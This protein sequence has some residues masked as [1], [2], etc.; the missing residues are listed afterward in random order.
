MKH[1]YEMMK[2]RMEK[3]YGMKDLADKVGLCTATVSKSRRTL[4]AP[5]WR[6]I[7]KLLLLLIPRWTSF[8]QKI[9]N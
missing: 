2:K 4:L 8:S 1:N 6:T 3:G 7:R 9:N 5:D